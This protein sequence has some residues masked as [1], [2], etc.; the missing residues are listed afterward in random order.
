[1]KRE[2]LLKTVIAGIAVS[3]LFSFKQY[4]QDNKAAAYV[5]RQSGLYLFVESVP[6]AEYEVLGRV[7]LSQV[8]RWERAT[9]QNEKEALIKKVLKEYP[10]ANGT[11]INLSN[12]N[13]F[14]D[15]IKIK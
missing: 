13:D 12:G 9:Y 7:K 14:A 8:I 2:T 15:A 4:K 5:N 1:M 10:S 11:I 3:F 6:A